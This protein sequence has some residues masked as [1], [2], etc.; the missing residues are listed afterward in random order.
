MLMRTSFSRTRRREVKA[1]F[2][3][4]GAVAA[5]VAITAP[6]LIGMTALAIDVSYLHLIRQEMQ[7]SAD[8]GAMTAVWALFDENGQRTSEGARLAAMEVAAMNPGQ[9]AHALEFGWIEDPSDP[10]S[11]FLVAAPDEANAF[12]VT[13]NRTA[14]SGNPVSLFFAGIFGKTVSDVSASA[15]TVFGPAAAVDGV[16][17]ALRAPGFGPIDP[18]IVAAN[19]GKDGPSEPLDGTSFKIGEQVTVFIFG[20]GK[21]SPVHLMLNTNDISGEAQ[22][23]KVLKG[24][25]P[26]VPLAIGDEIDILGEGTG[27]NGL[28]NK[29][30]DRL[31][32]DSSSND[33]IIVPIVETLPDTRNEDGELDGNVR[34]VDFLTV[35]LDGI[36]PATVPDPNDPNDMG[37]TIDIELLVGTIVQSTASGSGSSVASG[38]VDGISVGIPQL[39]R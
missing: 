1:S 34:V 29:L 5:L 2:R 3:R 10:A 27:H 16:P 25:E 33:Y 31:D 19:P 30:A 36:I 7:S 37:K 20:K 35:R 38:F 21:K 26:P 6:V 14:A 9:G 23:G 28:G 13:S 12:R 8:A 15:V 39:V 32:D 22:L 17:L 18:D 11:P 4:R 24:E